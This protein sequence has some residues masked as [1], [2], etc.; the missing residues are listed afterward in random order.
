MLKETEGPIVASS[1]FMKAVPEMIGGWVPRDYRVLGT[2][3]YGRSDTRAALR[4]FFEID[5]EHIVVAV[6]SA[7]AREKRIP[8]TT[9][10]RAIAEFQIDRDTPNPASR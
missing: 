1:D 9:V 3:G 7:L 10:V 2:D 6:L 8:S 4:R 5:A